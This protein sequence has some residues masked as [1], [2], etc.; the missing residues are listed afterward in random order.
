MKHHHPTH[1][2]VKGYLRHVPGR[3]AKVRV[4]PHLRKK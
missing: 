3:R 2:R 1:C 4:A